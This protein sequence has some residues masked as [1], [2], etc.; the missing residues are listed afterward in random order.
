MFG[1]LE[2]LKA[3][4]I[5]QVLWAEANFNGKS[6]A[7]KKAAVVKKID[8]LIVLPFYLE[9]MDDKIIAWLVDLACEKLNALTK[10]NFKG[11]KLSNEESLELVEALEAPTV[12]NLTGENFSERLNQLL[13]AT[14]KKEE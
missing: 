3:W 5:E 11:L 12:N 8:E 7:E 1:K 6:G 9:W 2:Q 14:K 4:A 10:H 13:L